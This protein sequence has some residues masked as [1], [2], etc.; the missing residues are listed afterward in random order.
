[1]EL[2]LTSVPWSNVST[3]DA[4]TVTKGEQL[5]IGLFG[6]CLSVACWELLQC[7]VWNYVVICWA[8]DD[9]INSQTSFVFGVA[10]KLCC[11]T[12]CAR[13]ISWWW[14]HC[15]CWCPFCKMKVRTKLVQKT[16]GTTK[17]T[18]LTDFFTYWTS[19]GSLLVQHWMRHCLMLWGYCHDAKGTKSC[20]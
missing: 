5:S 1:M 12:C 9:V 15:A 11:H 14:H 19:V 4:W 10:G 7:S 8:P 2:A 18:Y 13:M 16:A 20:Y 17:Q 6:Y 3:M